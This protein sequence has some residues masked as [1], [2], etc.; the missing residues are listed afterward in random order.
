M[1]AWRYEVIR[2]VASALFTA[3]EASGPDLDGA[4]DRKVVRIGY[5]V[6]GEGSCCVECETGAVLHVEEYVFT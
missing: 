2:P 4:V 1:V 6:E 5:D 3:D